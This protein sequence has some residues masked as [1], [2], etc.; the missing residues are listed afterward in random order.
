M[1][2]ENGDVRHRRSRQAGPENHTSRISGPFL[3]ESALQ[4][5]VHSGAAWHPVDVEIHE[6]L[7]TGLDT[8]RELEKQALDGAP[9][10]LTRVVDPHGL[11]SRG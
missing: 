11:V 8:Q 10:R 2:S 6:F 7:I 5:Q 4:F 1:A 3:G 9:P